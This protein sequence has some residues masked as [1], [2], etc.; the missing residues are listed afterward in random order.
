MSGVGTQNLPDVT[1][2]MA[3]D[4]GGD[5]IGRIAGIYLDDAT[6]EPEWAAVDLNGTEL[7]LVPLAGAMP[8][9]GGVQLAVSWQDI[10]DT[11]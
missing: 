11:P 7:T 8:T 9:G 1:G 3:F 5:E 2:Q 10:Q 4:Q 6:K